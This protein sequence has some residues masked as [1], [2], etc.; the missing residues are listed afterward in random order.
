MGEIMG[1]YYDQAWSQTIAINRG[2]EQAKAA[3]EPRLKALEERM[4][5]LE[6]EVDRARSISWPSAEEEA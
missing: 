1:G 3:L 6:R 5:K 2:A 4:D